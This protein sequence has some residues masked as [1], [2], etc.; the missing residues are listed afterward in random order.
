MLA[1]ITFITAIC[2]SAV[3]AYYSI[4]GLIAIFSAAVIPIAVMGI[5]LEVGKLVTASWLYNNWQETKWH[6]KS[7][8]TIAVLIL[9][10][11][12]SMGIFGFLSKAHI[13]Q[14]AGV[15]NNGLKI[16]R[17]ES[18]VERQQR[19][20]TR[21]EK[22]LNQFDQALEKYVDLGAVS[23]GLA[24]RDSQ[25][26]ERNRLDLVI[27]EAEQKIDSLLDDKN[28]FNQEIK[29]IE[30]EVGPI[31]YIAEL[32]YDDDVDSNILEKAVRVVIITIIFVFDPLA[33][34]LLVAAN[35]SFRQGRKRGV[36]KVISTPF[37]IEID[38]VD[39]EEENE[40]GTEET[41]NTVT[42]EVK[43]QVLQ[44]VMFDD[45]KSDLK[46]QTFKEGD[47]KGKV[48]LKN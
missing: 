3:A 4:L 25:S 37:G 8:L 14:V 15:D 28:K 10:F 43:P 40:N 16:E 11:I 38:E 21:A 1:I 29:E 42:E 48:F 22:T 23:K 27:T 34:L 44:E 46:E 20:I 7:Y 32:I 45:T 33:V 13:D 2:I 30:L 12:T 36:S 35:Q 5:V 18:S 19:E 39:M 47:V 6:L 31:K 26:E 17:I 24:K 41:A 9:M